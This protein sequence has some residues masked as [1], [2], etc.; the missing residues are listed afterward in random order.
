MLFLTN[1]KLQFFIKI[2]LLFF[3]LIMHKPF[4]CMGSEEIKSL[5]FSGNGPIFLSKQQI[6]DDLNQAS[7]LFSEN[8]I[9]YRV[10]ENNGINWEV[11]FQKLESLILKDKNPIL[12]HHFQKKLIK[13]LEFTEDSNIQADLFLKKRH[14]IQR[15]EPK[16]AFYTG[17]KLALQQKRFRVLPGVGQ[18]KNIINHSFINCSKSKE[19][20]F[21][22]LPQRQAELL[23]MLGMQSNH[24]HNHL[25]CKFE[26]ESGVKR[27]TLL[28]LYFSESEINF[29]ESPIFKY[30]NGRIPYVRWYR[31]GKN[32]ENEVKKFYKLAKKLRK[33]RDLII[34]V[35]G[36][37]N[38][39]FRFIEKWLG[40]Y[41]KSH[42]KNVIIRDRQTIPILKGL[43]N[44]V[45]WNLYH[46][47]HNLN[48]KRQLEQK[49]EQLRNLIYHF[50][51]KEHDQ[52]WIETKFIFNGKK[53]SPEWETHLIIIANNHCG[54]GCQFL[55]ALTKQIPYGT[56]IGKNTGSFPK[57]SFK[58]IFQLSSSKIML[59]FENKLHLNHLGEPVSTSGYHPD[60][61]LFSPMGFTE[62]MRYANK[63]N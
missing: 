26:S 47:S 40:D 41:T 10:F 18:K 43:L 28:P 53:N 55:S 57:N 30:V 32:E 63:K 8:Y 29:E 24:Q 14:Y 46:D 1:F 33:S 52:K 6:K 17:I 22:I 11:V 27:E 23:F 25:K 62:I 37:K 5:D 15:V 48:G 54:D 7:S 51:E 34:D 60:Y 12:T 50:I 4:F 9:R 36:N 61:W 35:R 21:P 39:S 19:V 59:T 38:G 49:R 58:P 44:R 42:W 3:P 20:F 45:Q 16:A 31:D 56:L 13:A 2:I